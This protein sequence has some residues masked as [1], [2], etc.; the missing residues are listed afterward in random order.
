MGDIQGQRDSCRRDPISDVDNE[1]GAILYDD[2]TPG[3][4]D[5]CVVHSFPNTVKKKWPA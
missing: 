1:S 3:P 5:C 2:C 4:T